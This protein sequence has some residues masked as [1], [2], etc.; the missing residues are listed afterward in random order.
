MI[1]LFQRVIAKKYLQ[2]LK[3]IDRASQR[4]QSELEKAMK[5]EGLSEMLSL[6]K[7]L[8][9]FSTSL[10]ANSAVLD[11]VPR[12]VKFFEED[13]DLYDDVV[14]ENK[15]AIGRKRKKHGNTRNGQKSAEND[16]GSLSLLS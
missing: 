16:R 6:E 10:R 9:Y 8:V 14:I 2:Y 1:D 11:K 5:N 7:A 12:L 13:E 4:V 15:Q 3:Q